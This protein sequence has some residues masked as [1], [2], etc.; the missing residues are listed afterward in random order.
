[1]EAR[2]RHL[3]LPG[4]IT[5]VIGCGLVGLAMGA[6]SWEMAIAVWFGVV[7]GAGGYAL[8]HIDAKES[9]G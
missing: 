1:M 2:V 9:R 5:T 6:S 3:A 7:N 4:L 8:G